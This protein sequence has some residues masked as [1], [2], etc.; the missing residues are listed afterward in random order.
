M[1]V[2]KSLST[3]LMMAALVS[4]A[5][6]SAEAEKAES[7]DKEKS[8][9][10][11]VAIAAVGEIAPDFT[12][13]DATGNKHT[14]ADYKG[15]YV[16]LEWTNFGCPFVKKHYN[17]ENM[18]MLQAKYT[19]E[20]VVWFSI[21]SSAPGKQGWFEGDDL[22][23]K[24][25]EFNSQASAYLVD[26]DG[27]VART[28]DAKTTPNMYIINPDGKLIYAGAIDDKASTNVD[29][30]PNSMNYVDAAMISAMAGKEIALNNTV[31]YGCSI[32]Y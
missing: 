27:K 11:I 26:A 20:D 1:N 28:Y 9:D 30:I 12:L 10:A 6:C 31:P 2:R 5:G 23:A 16:V 14:L 8:V 4:F 25:K 19:K 21:C 32:K 29:D 24:I 3:F 18:Q 15:K 7:T 17:S 13:T 22:L